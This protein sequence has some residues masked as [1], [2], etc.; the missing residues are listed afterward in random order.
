VKSETHTSRQVIVLQWNTDFTS[1]CRE[2]W[3][4]HFMSEVQCFI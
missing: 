3:N 4:T 2:E 1:G